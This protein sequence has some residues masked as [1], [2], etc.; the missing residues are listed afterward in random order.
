MI[1]VQKIV[2]IIVLFCC[3]VDTSHASTPAKFFGAT[4][5]VAGT[6]WAM[7]NLRT[8]VSVIDYP[9]NRFVH[10]KVLDKKTFIEQVKQGNIDYPIIRVSELDLVS[11]GLLFDR[12]KE[13]VK[14]LFEKAKRNA[15][16]FI[17]AQETEYSLGILSVLPG[18]RQDTADNFFLEEIK[19]IEASGLP[20]IIDTKFL[21]SVNRSAHEESDYDVSRKLNK[22]EIIQF[23]EKACQSIKISS[24]VDNS[25]LAALINGRQGSIKNDDC[26][27]IEVVDF[28]RYA[29]RFAQQDNALQ[30]E[31]KHFY[32]AVQLVDNSFLAQ[33]SIQL[34][35]CS[36]WYNEKNTAYHEA[37]HTLLAL[38]NDTGR[39][40]LCVSIIPCRGFHGEVQFAESYDASQTEIQ[41]YHDIM[42]NLAGAVV[43]QEIGIPNLKQFKDTDEGFED[44]L[45]RH[46]LDWGDFYLAR[47]KARKLISNIDSLTEDEIQQQINVILKKAYVD[48]VQYIK[49]NKSLVISLGDLLLE[50][51][52]LSGK[53]LQQWYYNSQEKLK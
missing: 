8:D 43:E 19:N 34:A 40:L 53:E 45:S 5:M 44:L 28:L 51:E 1:K 15:P 42:V 39:S 10:D 24:N 38:H 31:L 35:N 47:Y 23:L 52:I 11:S 2:Y 30:V 6:A 50:K 49:E 33:I 26:T 18:L 46:R 32:K 4:L 20:I 9:E 12:R 3:F 41:M 21:P 27:F 22:D 37:G 25:M 48:T 29:Q 16:C 14:L 17:I 36:L 13:R 7:D